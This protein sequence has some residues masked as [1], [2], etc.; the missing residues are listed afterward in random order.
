LEPLFK[1]YPTVPVGSVEHDRQL[2]DLMVEAIARAGYDGRVGLQVDVAAGTYLN[3]DGRR[4]VGLFSQAD[5]GR[6]ELMELYVQMVRDYPFVIIE[7]PLDEEDY[8]GH[9][10]LTRELGVEVVGDDLFATNAQRL[11][12][13]IE[14]DAANAV[15]LKVN[16]IGTISEA[17]DV[18]RLAFQHGM[19]VMPCSSRGE[20]ADIADYAVGLNTGHLR[21]GGTG[22]IANR[23]LEIEADLGR[24]AVFLG[25]EG[26]KP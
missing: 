26:L 2:W 5:K 7:D 18:A 8:E 25:R 4:F 14:M 6:D 3:H 22:P 10:W 20:G 17:F 13:G 11:Q 23:L 1:G 9:A 15:L 12:Q 24:R 19:G 16:Q 21:E